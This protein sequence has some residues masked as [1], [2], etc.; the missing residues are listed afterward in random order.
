MIAIAPG[1]NL[2]CAVDKMPPND[3][4]VAAIALGYALLSAVDRMGNGPWI[5]NPWFQGKDCGY[6]GF[7]RIRFSKFGRI[8]FEY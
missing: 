4:L 5:F 8:Q 1:Y 6:G 3:E 2:R 7:G